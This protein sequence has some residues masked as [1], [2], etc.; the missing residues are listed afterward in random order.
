[1]SDVIIGG[2]VEADVKPGKVVLPEEP[3]EEAL[4]ALL[5]A[6]MGSPDGDWA[7]KWKAVYR[8][9]YDHLDRPPDPH[10]E[11]NRRV[12]ARYDELMLE[13]KH[14]H[15]QMLCCVVA[16]EIERDRKEAGR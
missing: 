2:E 9:L 15:T 12:T 7:K 3:D 11:R 5:N 4:H 14:T 1:M 13:R 8:G 16:E 10:A 6:Y